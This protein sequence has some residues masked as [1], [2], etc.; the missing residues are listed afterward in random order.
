MRSHVSR[1]E[2]TQ[3]DQRGCLPSNRWRGFGFYYGI[4]R[5]EL[6]AFA[7]QER[8][9]YRKPDQE[10][11]SQ[12]LKLFVRDWAAKGHNEREDTFPCIKRHLDLGRDSEAHA[13]HCTLHTPRDLPRDLA[14]SC[15]T[16]L[17]HQILPIDV[18]SAGDHRS[19][20][21]LLLQPPVHL[22]ERY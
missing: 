8:A 18:S 4:D 17:G 12:A 6:D 22:F 10:S 5:E 2:A 19:F 3:V 15:V 9:A 21:L 14:K 7:R 1:A 13:A 20:C 16:H 11:V